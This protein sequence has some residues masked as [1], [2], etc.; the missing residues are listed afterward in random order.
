MIQ[1]SFIGR[2]SAVKMKMVD[3]KAKF[4]KEI[5]VKDVIA[6]SNGRLKNGI[7]NAINKI[8]NC[9]NCNPKPGQTIEGVDKYATYQ[10]KDIAPIVKACMDPDV[11]YVDTETRSSVKPARNKKSVNVMMSSYGVDDIDDMMVDMM[12]AEDVAAFEQELKSKE[13]ANVEIVDE[14]AEKQSEDVFTKK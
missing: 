12:D 11:R 13:R 10:I 1:T 5:A 9:V 3:R 4:N 2:G 7:A 6:Q 8:C 14:S